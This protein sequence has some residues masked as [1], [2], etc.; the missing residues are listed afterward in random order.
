MAERESKYIEK[1]VG[2]GILGAVLLKGAG[3][4]A[5][6]A[7]GVAREAWTRMKKK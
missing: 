2:F 5:G 7:F 1:A 4:V 6:A 3:L